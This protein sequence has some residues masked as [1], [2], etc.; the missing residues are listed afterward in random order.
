M[1]FIRKIV[2]SLQRAGV[3]YG[4]QCYVCC[5]VLWLGS[6]VIVSRMAV[7]Y[8][9]TDPFEFKRKGIRS[10]THNKQCNSTDKEC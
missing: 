9:D 4:Q 2:T 7:R 8:L 6:E 1:N 10:H 3:Y 5:K